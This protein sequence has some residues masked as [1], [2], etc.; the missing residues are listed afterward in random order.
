MKKREKINGNKARIELQKGNF[1]FA[2]IYFLLFAGT[3]FFIFW[4]N[5][6]LLSQ[7]ENALPPMARICPTTDSAD[8]QSVPTKYRKTITSNN[9][10]KL[11]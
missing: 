3:I 6:Y 10:V 4:I 9:F 2:I 11:K 7:I 1:L 8:M 5:N